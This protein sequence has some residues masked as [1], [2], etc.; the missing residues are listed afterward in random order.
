MFL[1]EL[2][3]FFITNKYV[4]WII[5]SHKKNH[6]PDNSEYGFYFKTHLL[7]EMNQ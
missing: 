3:I 6:I 4:L 7:T 1:V 5:I 2:I